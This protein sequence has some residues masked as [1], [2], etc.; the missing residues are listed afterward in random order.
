MIRFD[1]STL[2]QIRELQAKIADVVPESFDI[3]PN[4]H[5]S[6]IPSA[7]I[8]SQAY[9]DIRSTVER[10][11]TDLD[12]IRTGRLVLHPSFLPYVVSLDVESS[13]H[14]IRSPLINQIY[15]LGGTL[16][17]PP[18]N[19]HITLYKADN[20]G[21]SPPRHTFSVYEKLHCEI[22]SVVS[23]SILTNEIVNSVE[24]RL[25]EF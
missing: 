12:S 17:Y 21:H 14:Q 3:E 15:D 16:Q 11:A 8:P 1:P 13:L 19:P 5:I 20:E 25:E 24:L 2:D 18:V 6:V 22:K 4:P 9:G 7:V 23:D 10:Y